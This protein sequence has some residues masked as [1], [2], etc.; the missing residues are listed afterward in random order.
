MRVAVN[1]RFSGLPEAEGYANFTNGLILNM[2]EDFAGDEFILMYDRQPNSVMRNR[3]ITQ[4]VRG[5]RARHPLL[6]KW[7]YDVS[8]TRMAGKHKADVI[9][10]PDGFCSL[11]SSIPQVLAIHDL[12][13]LHFPEG[14]NGIYRNY[15]RL[16]T[17][18]FLKKA[19]HIVTVSEFSRQDIVKHYPQA[20]D[21]ISVVYNDADKRFAPVDWQVR[22]SL[23]EKHAE[24]R[25]YFLY[26]GSIHPRKNLVT[27]LK[28]FSWFK[29]RHQTNMKLVLAGRMAWK[30]DEFLKLLSTYKFRDDVI[31]KGYVQQ[32]DMFEL[33]AAAYALV[34]PSYWEGFGLPVLEAMRSGVPVITSSDSAM[35]EVAGDAGIYLDPSDPEAWGRMMGLL[36]KDEA[37]RGECIRKGLLRSGFFS[38]K[39]SAAKLHQILAGVAGACRPTG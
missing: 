30:N 6:W 14:I 10:S 13:F 17:P 32:E 1:T 3:N 7:W 23:K 36:Y 21:K 20:K 19:K 4:V 12:A 22:E 27:L 15:Y 11:T 35:Q 28:G 8:M 33:M 25:E 31:L 2:S 37:L 29:K 9:F 18:S 38:W 24:G 34:Y 26:A 5:P 16:F 39:E